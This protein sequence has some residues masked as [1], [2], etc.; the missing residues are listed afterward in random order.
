[1]KKKLQG[2]IL[3][4]MT[5]L[6]FSFVLFVL[7]AGIGF[8]QV[9]A[10]LSIDDN[11]VYAGEYSEL[12]LNVTNHGFA[13]VRDVTAEVNIPEGLGYKWTEVINDMQA[14]TSIV[15]DKTINTYSW[16]EPEAYEI[17]G[18]VKFANEENKIDSLVLTVLQFPLTMEHT[19]E[20]VEGVQKLSVVIENVDDDALDNVVL[21]VVFPQDFEFNET[22]FLESDVLGAGQEMSKNFIFG[23]PSGLS[24]TYYI[25]L[26]LSFMD[27]EGKHEYTDTIDVELGGY[28]LGILELVLAIVVILL[29]A[30]LVARR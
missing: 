1:M 4:T 12:H 18:V 9:E 6:S 25:E 2:H 26:H 10:Y 20:E 27:A 30:R 16:T 24:G 15:F 19:L 3:K 22:R 28:S 21:E 13:L 23:I 11:V 7:F 8:G 5:S 17:D 29:I 14:R